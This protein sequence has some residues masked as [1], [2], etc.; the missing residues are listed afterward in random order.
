VN[1]GV[2]LVFKFGPNL[3]PI[4][5]PQILA[6][7]GAGCEALDRNATFRRRKRFASSPLADKPLGNAK[8]FGDG[9]LLPGGEVCL[10]VHSGILVLLLFLVKR[11]SNLLD[12][13]ILEPLIKIAT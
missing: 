4:F 13:Q 7:H 6:T 8:R 5:G 2:T 10:E 11:T 12:A 3:A 9:P 1:R